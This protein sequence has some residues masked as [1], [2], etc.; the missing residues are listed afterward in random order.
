MAE[1]IECAL[2]TRLRAEHEEAMVHENGVIVSPLNGLDT[3]PFTM[4]FR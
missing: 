3:T 2:S 4:S 1:G